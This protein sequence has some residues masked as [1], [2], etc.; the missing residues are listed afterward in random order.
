MLFTYQH[1]EN[2]P[3]YQL[4][5]WL[6][7]LFLNVWCK[8][9]PAV[10]YDIELLPSEIKKITLEI[11]NDDR[12]KKDYLYGPIQK[13]YTFFQALDDPIKD[14]LAK[15]YQDN[16]CIIDLCNSQN[17][18]EPFRYKELE[19]IN[20]NLKKVLKNFYKHL[21]T[22][23]IHLKAVTSRTGKLEKHYKE[24]VTVN[25]ED[26]CPFCGINDLKGRYSNRKDAYDHFLPKS[27]YPF[28]SVNFLNLAPMC[29]DCNSSYKGPKDPLIRKDKITRRKAFY[30]YDKESPDI[31]LSIELLSKDIKSLT[32]EDIG[33]EIT[34]T[35]SDEQ[36]EAWN[37]IFGIEERY[38]KKCL[39]KNDGKFWYILAT[40][41][42]EGFPDR[43]KAIYPKEEW[44]QK[45]IR[46]AETNKNAEANFIKAEFLKALQKAELV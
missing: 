33:L 17:G 19:Q 12:I 29:Y 14:K 34:C 10:E 28:N 8:A 32:P 15:A 22:N 16:N 21:F 18:C 11:Y 25:D 44:I 31:R 43:V 38:K 36:V 40:D 4:Q 41:E 23:V 1:I 27:V 24:F 30:V 3:I 2:H 7:D 6:D 13:V 5:E 26:K 37:E 46:S 20:K 9:D 39:S 45:L 42:Y 35:D